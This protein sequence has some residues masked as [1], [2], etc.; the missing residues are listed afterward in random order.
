[1]DRW[2]GNTVSSRIADPAHRGSHCFWRIIF[3]ARKLPALVLGLPRYG[4]RLLD[5]SFSLGNS[6]QG[7]AGRAAAFGAEKLKSAGGTGSV[8][9]H[10]VGKDLALPRPRFL[11]RAVEPERRIHL[12]G[13]HSRARL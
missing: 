8:R 12:C 7:Y 3:P 9:L 11:S 13:G 1:I 2:R 6:K 4:A 10:G 5:S